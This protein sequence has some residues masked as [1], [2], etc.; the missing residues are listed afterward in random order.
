[1]RRKPAVFSRKRQPVVDKHLR[2]GI[3][4][5]LLA[6][7]IEAGH[8]AGVLVEA[9]AFR[10]SAQC[11][12][13]RAHP[14]FKLLVG[15]PLFVDAGER[16]Q[17]SVAAALQGEDVRAD[18]ARRS[19]RCCTRLRPWRTTDVY[20]V[21][22]VFARVIVGLLAEAQAPEL[23][24]LWVFADDEPR[25]HGKRGK[26]HHRQQAKPNEENR[27]ADEYDRHPCCEVETELGS[28]P[29]Q[30]LIDW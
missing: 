19:E 22:S 30:R 21:C 15:Q 25:A 23:E 1:M 27:Y 7:K 29:I 4:V 17:A 11:A 26:G 9:G 14:R 24:H 6:R 12:F 2:D 28:R 16:K 3:A 13:N 18:E 5:L 10:Q 20:F 8:D